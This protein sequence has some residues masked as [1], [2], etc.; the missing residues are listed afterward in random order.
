MDF[1]CCQLS[2]HFCFVRHK[3][4]IKVLDAERSSAVK[5]TEMLTFICREIKHWTKAICHQSTKLVSLKQLAVTFNNCS[6]S[7]IY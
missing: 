1:T 5:V 6:R 3:F 7:I 4:K 2:N